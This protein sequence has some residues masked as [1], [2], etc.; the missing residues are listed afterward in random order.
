MIDFDEIMT[1]MKDFDEQSL[2]NNDFRRKIIKKQ[3]K[4]DE[5]L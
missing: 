4:N 5:T 3:M 1:K 2:K